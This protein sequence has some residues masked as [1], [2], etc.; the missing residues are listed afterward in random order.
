MNSRASLP[1][2]R[3]VGDWPREGIVTE[4]ADLGRPT[5]LEIEAAIDR[6]WADATQRPGVHLF[7]GPMSRLERSGVRP[8][9]R[10][11]LVLSRT[12]Y[13]SFLGTNLTR[14]D[15]ADRFGPAALANP[16]GVSVALETADRFLLL[17]RRNDAVAYYPGRIHPFAG[18]LEPDADRADVFA[19]AERELREELS[20]DAAELSDLRCTGLAEDPALRQPELI[21]RVRCTLRRPQVE[22]KLDPVEHR[23]V[24]A[25]PATPQGVASALAD[26]L[27]TPVAVASLL[28][29][30]RL[31]FGADWFDKRLRPS[32]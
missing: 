25:V 28:L 16:L 10:L 19:A 29:W 1:L 2:F 20:L 9:G 3:H 11:H 14:P 27:L 24:F 6:A 15:L 18:A 22:E 4:T 30:G 17:G 31:E 5:D 12:D 26:P 32:I 21:F 23:G 13:K 8:D 7:N